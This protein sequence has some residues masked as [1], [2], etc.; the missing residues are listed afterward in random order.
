MIDKDGFLTFNPDIKEAQSLNPLFSKVFA[1]LDSTTISVDSKV[2][3]FINAFSAY[4]AGEYTKEFAEKLY[5]VQELNISLSLMGFFLQ[6]ALQDQ[7]S[8]ACQ[9]YIEGVRKSS[10]AKY[11]FENGLQN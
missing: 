3:S 4:A 10:E 2:S 7:W 6:K 9:E 11:F 8:R 1:D 5:S